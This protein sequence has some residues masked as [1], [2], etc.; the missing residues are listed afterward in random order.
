MR[1]LLAPLFH[2]LGKDIN[3]ISV[4]VNRGEYTTIIIKYMKEEKQYYLSITNFEL[5]LYDVFSTDNMIDTNTFE[6]NNKK[7]IANTFKDMQYYFMDDPVKIMS[8]SKKFTI[9]DNCDLFTLGDN[10]MNLFSISSRH[11]YYESNKQLFDANRINCTYPKLNVLLHEKDNVLAI[12]KHL[13]L[14]EE[15]VVKTLSKKTLTYS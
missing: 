2:K 5:G 14:Y 7:I 15:D 10:N 11:S 8:T 3:I 13:H 9:M 1:E 4:D 12:Y 6:I